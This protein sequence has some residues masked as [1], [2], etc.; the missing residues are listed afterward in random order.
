MKKIAITICLT[1]FFL[2]NSFALAAEKDNILLL[3]TPVISLPKKKKQEIDKVGI[4]CGHSGTSPC[5]AGFLAPGTLVEAWAQA[6]TSN[7][8]RAVC[9]DKWE[10]KII[11]PACCT[12]IN[13]PGYPHNGEEVHQRFNFTIGPDSGAA[14]V[15]A[16][17]TDKREVVGR[18]LVSSAGEG[19]SG[20]WSVLGGLLHLSHVA[21]CQVIG[22]PA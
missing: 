16:L 6:F 20:Q 5:P 11:N 10:W 4:Y 19:I 14:Q 9:N 12:V 2:S 13:T 17:C 7:G 18:L 1:L 15:M 8:E 22:L 21:E 3:I